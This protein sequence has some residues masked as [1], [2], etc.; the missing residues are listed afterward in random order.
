VMPFGRDKGKHSSEL[1]VR[2]LRWWE[3]VY[4]RDVADEAK[5]QFRERNEARLETIRAHLREKG[6]AA[7]HE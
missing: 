6:E 3:A 1:D 2:S 4:R 7:N 5:A